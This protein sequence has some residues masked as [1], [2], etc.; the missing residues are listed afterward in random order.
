MT[1]KNKIYRGSTEAVEQFSSKVSSLMK[2]GYMAMPVR[3]I[4]GDK[5]TA[6]GWNDVLN[7]YLSPSKCDNGAVDPGMMFSSSVSET[8][9]SN[10]GTE[11]LGYMNWGKDNALPN[12]VALLSS[13]LPYT[14]A[15]NRFNTDVAAGLG[16]RPKYRY[17]I[18]INDTLT[19]K[20]IDYADAGN[21]IHSQLIEKRKKLAEFY[22]QCRDSDIFLHV[23]SG[24]TA[25]ASKDELEVCKKI[26]EDFKKEISGLESDYAQWEKTNK[27]LNEFLENTS[28]S[29][30]C[31]NLF[32]GMSLFDMCYPEIQLSQG[33]PQQKTWKPKVT[34]IGFYDTV[35]CRLERMDR[36]NKINYVYVSNRFLDSS[37]K[38]V[39]DQMELMAIPALDPV[40][41]L[42]SLR[43]KVRD[44]R[45]RAYYGNKKTADGKPVKESRPTR[46]ILPSYI[47][48]AGKSYYP[49]PAWWSIFCGGIFQYAFN[50]IED[51]RL[52]K[53][54]SNMWGKV[55]YIHTEYLQ[56]IYHDL[57]VTDENKRAEIRNKMWNEINTFLKDRSK[58]RSTLLSFT[59]MGTD[60]KEHDAYRIVDVPASSKSEAEAQ[61]TE[62]QE[63]S[64]IIFFSMQIH[65][66][67]IGS[68][69]GSRSS[70]GGTYLRE[71]DL[72]K[73][74]HMKSVQAIVLSAFEV[75]SRFNEWDNH[76]VWRIQEYN[77]STLDR[78]ATGITESEVS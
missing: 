3:E 57:N 47:P 9:V 49:Q 6:P 39:N 8:I 55:I 41:P 43:D 70:S 26:E 29:T 76:L 72:L 16:P 32:T 46:F 1:R 68:I 21:L 54:N 7:T 38:N 30:V 66:E 65:A 15:G 73:Q 40:R 33:N 13:L 52:A 45:L 74:L 23:K 71:M 42:A 67:Q 50:I 17:T 75:S 24:S 44:A 61:K 60:G 19:V 12:R 64:S 59:F 51:R 35:M 56:Q 78:S 18:V 58:N 2:E 5:S 11:G 4:F 53:A 77:L 37:V 22:K 34:G 31:L 69:P 27:E 28:L 48:A 62:L 36:N 63:V 20:E 14:A 10:I 25:K